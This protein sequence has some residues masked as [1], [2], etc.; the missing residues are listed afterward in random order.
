MPM[1][2]PVTD[3]GQFQQIRA[4]VPPPFTQGHWRREMKPRFK[5]NFKTICASAALML[6]LSSGQTLAAP[7][8]VIAYL[9]AES[10]AAGAKATYASVIEILGELGPEMRLEVIANPGTTQIFDLVTPADMKDHPDWRRGFFKQAI[11]SL[12]GHAK[13]SFERG[14]SSGVDPANQVG[15]QDILSALPTRAVEKPEVIIFGSPRHNAGNDQKNNIISRFPNDKFLDLPVQFS[16]YGTKGIKSSL[17]GMRVHVCLLDDGFVDPRHPDMLERFTSLRLTELGGVLAT[18]SFDTKECARRALSSRSDGQRTF[19]RNKREKTPAFYEIEE[20][21]AA[22]PTDLNVQLSLLQNMGLSQ[23]VTTAMAA[24]ISS[25]VLELISVQVYDTNEEDGD[26]VIIK[27]DDAEIEVTLTKA[28]QRVTLPVVDGMVT[29]VGLRDGNGG[30]TV[31]IETNDGRQSLTPV[32][33]VGEV[34]SI[35]FFSQ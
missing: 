31:G 21:V 9:P 18:W 5:T 6:A 20:V 1:C 16:R 32:M 11:K 14:Q 15:L 34:I 28:R 7:D 12:Q 33:S 24:K 30:I 17:N 2:G 22:P 3:L 27:S 25:G 13:L 35:P 4:A 26:A 8:H 10:N 23:S 29:M 19:T